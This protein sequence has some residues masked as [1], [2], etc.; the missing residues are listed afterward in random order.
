M[1]VGVRQAAFVPRHRTRA[2]GAV[3]PMLVGVAR[4]PMS[5][6]MKVWPLLL[7]A[8]ARCSPA[9]VLNSL[10]PGDGVVRQRDIA[11]AAGPRHALDSYAPRDRPAAATIVFLYGGAWRSGSK[12]LYG[13][14]GNTLARAGFTVAIPDYRLYPAV[15]YPDFLRDNAAAVAFVQ[16]HPAEF[17]PPVFL[18]GH[19]AGAY[20]AAMLALD[21]QW[22]A[23]AGGSADQIRGLIGLAGPYDFLPMTGDTRA[24]FGAAVDDPAT[25][26]VRYARADAPPA[27]LLAGADDRTVKPRNTQALAARLEAAGAA[28]RV[29]IT[30]GLG[31]V[32]LLLAIA[33]LFQWRGPV[34][35]DVRAFVAAPRGGGLASVTA[36]VPNPRDPRISP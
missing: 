12:A 13:F 4:Q 22:L 8:L 20:N 25:Q 17:A 27:L 6:S 19:S 11:Y 24:V 26:P 3:H 18:M 31:H 35:R 2:I 32:G 33:P 16:A 15:R 34:L 5:G 21:R 7:V 1:R 29:A 30:P 10:T 28:V 36:A 14:V 23:A 9:D